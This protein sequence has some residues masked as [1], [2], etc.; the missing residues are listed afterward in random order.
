M[1]MDNFHKHWPLP[2]FW[3][4]DRFDVIFKCAKNG[5]DMDTTMKTLEED[6]LKSLTH[7]IMPEMQYALIS[8][9]P[10]M[11]LAYSFTG[12][13]AAWHLPLPPPREP[14]PRAGRG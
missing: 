10:R 3:T 5:G 6:F 7:Y 14:P 12:A 11:H 2:N 9:E 1:N 13:H 4:L 8:Y